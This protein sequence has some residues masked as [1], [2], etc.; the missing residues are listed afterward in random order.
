[1]A[2]QVAPSCSTCL[3]SASRVQRTHGTHPR[4]HTEVSTHERRKGLHQGPRW[5]GIPQNIVKAH[6]LVPSTGLSRTRGT[7]AWYGSV[8]HL[9]RVL[10]PETCACSCCSPCVA[11]PPP[12]RVRMTYQPKESHSFPSLMLVVS[13]K[14]LTASGS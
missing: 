13:W 12:M 1:M 7:H 4:F 3:S 9:R 14:T 2:R 10:W 8:L 6:L 11:T 5:S